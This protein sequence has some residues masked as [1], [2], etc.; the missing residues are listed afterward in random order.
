MRDAGTEGSGGSR[1]GKGRRAAPLTGTTHSSVA[2][3]I[4]LLTK[5]STIWDVGEV[6][7][8]GVPARATFLVNGRGRGVAEETGPLARTAMAVMTFRLWQAWR[9]TRRAR[10]RSR[11]RRAWPFARRSKLFTLELDLAHPVVRVKIGVSGILFDVGAGTEVMAVTASRAN[12]APQFGCRVVVQGG[13]EE[14]RWT[15]PDTRAGR[16]TEGA[17]NPD[18]RVGV[19]EPFERDLA[20][21]NEDMGTAKKTNESSLEDVNLLAQVVG[22][23]GDPT[24]CGELA[25]DSELGVGRLVVKRIG[26]D[27]TIRR[28]RTPLQLVDEPLY[29]EPPM[30]LKR[31]GLGGAIGGATSD[32][33][34]WEAANVDR[35]W[36]GGREARADLLSARVE[37]SG[38]VNVL[39]D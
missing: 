38:G 5:G 18:V 2:G 31:D 13:V 3:F 25:S 10:R 39:Q 32:N 35:P 17:S 36:R 15:A 6:G 24:V 19:E 29:G 37:H 34:N 14:E 1:T 9:R 23:V 22:V 4:A 16:E 11:V 21:A 20:A 27:N 28:V 8:R 30:F 7:W 26:T 12:D 33:E